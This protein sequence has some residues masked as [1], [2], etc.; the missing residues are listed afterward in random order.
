M[1]WVSN[2]THV[3]VLLE[4]LDGGGG[5]SGVH[6]SLKKLT[7]YSSHSDFGLFIK[8]RPIIH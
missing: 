3:V 4:G 6:Y 2:K 7:D 5:G 1:F 8:I